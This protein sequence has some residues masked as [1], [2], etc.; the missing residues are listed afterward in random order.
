MSRTYSALIQNQSPSFKHLDVKR[1][2]WINV[3]TFSRAAFHDFLSHFEQFTLSI[4]NKPHFNKNSLLMGKPDDFFSN[5]LA[6]LTTLPINAADEYISTAFWTFVDFASEADRMPLMKTLQFD[7]FFVSL[8]LARFLVGHKA[9][10]ELLVLR[11][12]CAAIETNG[13]RP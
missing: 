13:G 2:L 1:I 3:S 5:Y 10:L 12:C 7:S 6:N 8:G 11:N 9:T 4:I